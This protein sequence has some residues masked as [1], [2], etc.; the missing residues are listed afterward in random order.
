MAT[1]ERSHGAFGTLVHVG[2]KLRLREHRLV[3]LVEIGEVGL[4]PLVRVER[5]EHGLSDPIPNPE[6][7][8]VADHE[9]RTSRQRHVW[10]ML[11]YGE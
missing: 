2:L 9:L 5:A 6:Q 8:N 4:A 11:H 7:G 3:V 10:N 1:G